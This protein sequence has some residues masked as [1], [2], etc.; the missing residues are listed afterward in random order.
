[1]HTKP[2]LIVCIKLNAI[3]TKH[4]AKKTTQG[5][6]YQTNYAIQIPI[7]LNQKKNPPAVKLFWM[8]FSHEMESMSYGSIL[9]P[10]KTTQKFLLNLL[11]ISSKER[12]FFSILYM[13]DT[14]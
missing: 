13:A 5:T 10:R 3:H 8:F 6:Y 11:K 12:Q 9:K 2:A 1:M 7:N 14:K 4:L